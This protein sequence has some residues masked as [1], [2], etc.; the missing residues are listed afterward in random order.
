MKKFKSVRIMNTTRYKIIKNACFRD[1]I[2]IMALQ[3]TFVMQS[4]ANNIQDY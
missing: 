4:F 2:N 1:L 3:N